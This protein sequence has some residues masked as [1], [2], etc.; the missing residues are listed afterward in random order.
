MQPCQII[1]SL[2]QVI[3]Q[4]WSSI[5]YC[6]VRSAFP[7][8]SFKLYKRWGSYNHVSS[9]RTG[10]GGTVISSNDLIRWTTSYLAGG[11]TFSQVVSMSTSQ[12]LVWSPLLLGM[13]STVLCYA[14]MSFLP[15]SCYRNR[16]AITYTFLISI[17]AFKILQY[18]NIFTTFDSSVSWWS[19]DI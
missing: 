10:G 4:G 5:T 18:I 12:V 13:I 2:L 11:Q 7:T 6:H 17:L 19:V 8:S 16:A 9:Y 1:I 3:G 15:A 14:A